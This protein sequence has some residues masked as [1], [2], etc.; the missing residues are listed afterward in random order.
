MALIPSTAAGRGPPA[1]S[2]STLGEATGEALFVPAGALW[3]AHETDG[4]EAASEATMRADGIPTERL[5]PAE[6][7]ARWPQLA[8]DDLTFAV[9]EPEAGLLMARR[10]V[11]AVARIFKA[12]GGAFELAWVE[13]GARDGRRLQDVVDA[14]GSRHE[15]DR[16]VFACG[17]WLPRL[18]P[19]V[20]GGR[21]PVTKQDVVFVGP[22]AGD[23]R[24]GADQLP[25][26]VDYGAAF[27]G[28]PAVDGRR[29]EGRPGSLRTGLRPD[30][31][32]ADRRPGER[33]AG[34][35]L[36]GETLPRPGRRTRHR[37]PGLPVRD[38][39][40]TPTSSSIATPTTTT[41]GSSA[42]ARATVSSTDRRSGATSSRGWP[43]RRRSRERSASGSVT[44]RV[45]QANL[46]TGADGMVEGWADW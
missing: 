28:I 36:P 14:N 12:E 2:G 39:R 40:R 10:G 18:F 22:P 17:P 45:S 16:F 26:W 19:D 1:R 43:A 38:D 34:P 29:H 24:F 6:I 37:D 42:A 11:A 9:Y 13:P 7:S 46:R 21:D 33:A 8:A 5:S 44:S 32:R 15:A 3:F 35:P 25:C 30:P 4:F 41:C 31:R 27:Y 20:L 23:A